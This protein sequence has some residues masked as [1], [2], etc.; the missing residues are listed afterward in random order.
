MWQY[1]VVFVDVERHQPTD[2]RDALERVEE[3]P[4]MFFMKRPVKLPTIVE[5][6]ISF[7]GTR[8][9]SAC[10]PF[11]QPRGARANGYESP[12]RQGDSPFYSRSCLAPLV[13]S[14]TNC[15]DMPEACDGRWSAASP[16][17]G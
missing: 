2:G 14:F 3:E 5:R 4:L 17:T 1:V 7:S 12:T 11:S 9:V 13:P 15:W 10:S 16:S 6:A 8:P